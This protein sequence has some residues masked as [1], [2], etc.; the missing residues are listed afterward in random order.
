ME[1]KEKKT[2]ELI[3]VKIFLA[4]QKSWEKKL[5]DCLKRLLM[6]KTF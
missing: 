3:N 6:Q 4:L 2:N 5:K 1:E